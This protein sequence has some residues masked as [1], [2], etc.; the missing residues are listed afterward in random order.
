[1]PNDKGRRKNK[2]LCLLAG[3]LAGVLLGFAG[4]NTAIVTIL[5]S[6]VLGVFGFFLPDISTRIKRNK[7]SRMYDIDM[8]DYLTNVAMLLTSGLTLWESLKRGT[9]GTDIKRPLYRELHKAFE[10]LDKGVVTDPVTA[11]EQM[12]AEVGVPSVS[13]LA[14][15]VAQNY[16]KGAGEV[17]MLMQD[18]AV[19]SRANRKNVCM[20]L[21]DE[22]TT[23]LL[24][25]STMLLI[26]LIAL[27]VT[28]AILTLASI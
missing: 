10:K 19:S 15:V 7:E 13:M 6:I 5:I 14:G 4:R 23:L 8:A 22:A 11:F 21:A 27:L 3:V 17:A 18:F 26:A 12:A 2:I 20:K 24:I 1:M 28:P 9:D 16:R 25:P